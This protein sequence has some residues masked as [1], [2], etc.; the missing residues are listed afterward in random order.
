MKWSQH[1]YITIEGCENAEGST[2]KKLS[3]VNEETCPVELVDYLKEL[4]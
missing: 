2:K 4:I 1:K 3:I